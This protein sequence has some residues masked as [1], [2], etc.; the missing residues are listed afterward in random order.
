MD[1][2]AAG[3]FHEEVIADV[4]ARADEAYDLLAGGLDRAAAVLPT[5]GSTTSSCK[6]NTRPP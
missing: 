4:L 1:R 6:R 2:L 3:D 5:P